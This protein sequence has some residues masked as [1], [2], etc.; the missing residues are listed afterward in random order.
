MEDFGNFSFWL[1]ETKRLFG[2]ALTKLKSTLWRAKVV[3][4]EIIGVWLKSISAC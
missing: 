1:S 3:L 2:R 4:V